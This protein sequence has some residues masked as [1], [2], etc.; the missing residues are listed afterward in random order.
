M[1]PITVVINEFSASTAGTDV[2]YVELFSLPGTD[3]SGYT[4]V[5]IEGDSGATAGT[6][7]SATAVTGTTDAEGILLLSL[8]ANTIENGT[9][10]LLLVK[11][12]TGSTGTDRDADNDGTLDATPWAEIA[13]GVA[14]NDG[15]AGDLAYA[16]VVLGPNYDGLSTFAPGGAS[17]VPDGEDTGTAA[18]WARNDFD[19]A[20][21]AGFTGTPQEGEALNTPGAPNAL[22]GDDS[23]SGGEPEAATIMQVQGSG[24]VSAFV[25]ARVTTSGIVTAVDSNGFYMQD[26]AGDGDV[27]TSDGIFVFTGSRPSLA[28]GDAVDVEGRVV[29]FARN[30]APGHLT[31]TQIDNA[32]ITVT[33]S[34]NTLPDAVVIG[35]GGRLPPTDVTDDD[36]FASY[37]PETDGVDFFESLEGMRVQIN[38][39][40]AVAPSF[41]S[42]SNPGETWVVGDGG[43][44]ATGLNSRGGLTLTESD[45]NPERIQ[46]QADSGILPGFGFST[47]VGDT[48]G[49]IVGVM[50]YDSRGNFE[51]LPTE[52]FTIT[53]G[54]LAREATELAGSESTLL[55]GTFNVENLDPSDDKFG[56]LGQQIAEALNAPDIIALQEIQDNSGQNDDGITDASETYQALI[57]AIVAA[58]GPE[59]EF[60]DVAPANNTAGGAPGGNIRVGY[61]YNPARVDLVEES[62]QQVLDSDLSDGNAWFETRIPLRADF[63]FQGDPVTLINNHWSSKGGS[64]PQFGSIQPLVN[65]SEDQ[66]VAQAQVL[67][68]YVADILAA[69]AE[70]AVMVLGDLNEFP[71]EDALDIVTG[72][73]AGEQIL[74]NVFEDQFA[75]AERFEYVFDGN[76]QVLDHVLV[77]SALR[78]ITVFDPV[79]VNSQWGVNDPGRSSDHDPAVAAIAFPSSVADA[80]LSFGLFQDAVIPGRPEMLWAGELASLVLEEGSDPVEVTGPVTVSE[81]DGDVSVFGAAFANGA[82][83]SADAPLVSLD[84]NEGTATLSHLAP[85]NAIKVLSLIAFTGPALTLE[86][87]VDVDVDLTALEDAIDLA[88]D[89]SKRGEIAT[90]A[91]DDVITIGADSNETRWSNLFTIDTGA[92]DDTVTVGDASRAYAAESFGESFFSANTTVEIR[93]GE[94]DDAYQGTG[95]DIAVYDGAIEGYLITA[96][97]GGGVQVEDIDLG[98]GDE[99][100]DTLLGVAFIRA[101]G[102]TYA[103]DD[104]F[105]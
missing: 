105:A 31:I 39:A 95:R 40:L 65:G 84:W 41:N 10:T 81:E 54:G 57:E 61:L 88:V 59:Y 34:G 20:G 2:E 89:G 55:V 69:D 72:R 16:D 80:L 9:V 82:A 98:D 12:F 97:E 71:W 51:V 29:E 21:I 50:D 56:L 83:F 86:G 58:G 103:L 22:V 32:D 67:Y 96:L 38:E 48:L 7:D 52:A 91:G 44:N 104:L 5:Q 100:T 74:F 66:R 13:D 33:S 77:S 19:L 85:W 1:D 47:N 28:T 36:G 46:V 17:R 24:H 79:H 70:A 102:T 101:G 99:G 75:E 63:V 60:F 25:N 4:L 68:E 78:Q 15:G 93:L 90:G 94:G 53:P 27:A 14:V 76:H 30:G 45:D 43:A 18:D 11:D 49:T 62:V 8:A 26:P 37:D 23:G 64:S 3:L 87:W 6:I 35:S 73:D 42:G 92:G